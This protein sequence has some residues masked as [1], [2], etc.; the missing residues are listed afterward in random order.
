MSAIYSVICQMKEKSGNE[1][2]EGGVLSALLF[3]ADTDF[4]IR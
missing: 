2:M 1:A 3:N 4:E